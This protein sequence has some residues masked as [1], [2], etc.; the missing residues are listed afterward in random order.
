MVYY[1]YHGLVLFL[2][3]IT[4]CLVETVDLIWSFMHNAWTR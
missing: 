4:V 3:L 1:F 2:I